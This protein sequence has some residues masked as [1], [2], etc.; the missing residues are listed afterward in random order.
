MLE[1]FLLSQCP[2]SDILKAQQVLQGYCEMSPASML[3]RRL[4]WEAPHVPKQKGFEQLFIERQHPQRKFL[5]QNMQA[6][7]LRQAYHVNTVY[8]VG[9]EGFA[10]DGDVEMEGE[11]G[12]KKV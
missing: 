9:R 12:E 3:N 5:W 11:E 7:L 2:D 6:A 8:A 4:L 1:L 10:G